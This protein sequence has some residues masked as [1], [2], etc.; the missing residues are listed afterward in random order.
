M[1]W[2][3]VLA[4]LPLNAQYSS[5]ELQAKRERLLQEIAGIQKELEQTRRSRKAGAEQVRTLQQ[6]IQAR[7]RLMQN[8]HADLQRIN[9]L[10]AQKQTS[11]NALQQ[12]LEDLKRSYARMVVY[13]YKNRS[14]KSWITFL[15]ASDDFNDALRR[16]RYVR[17]YNDYRRQ[18][19][20]LIATAQADLQR[21]I[22]QLN[23]R[24]QEQQRLLDQ[25]AEQR[26]LLLREKQ[27][28]DKLLQSLSRQEKELKKR[29]DQKQKEQ[30]KLKKQIA[31]RIRK[32]LSSDK[33]ADRS[34][35]GK[36]ERAA[37]L[38]PEAAALSKSFAANQGK[39]PWPVERGTITERFGTHAHEVFGNLKIKNNGI[40]IQTTKG[41]A[42]RAIFKGT[43]I[44]ILSNPAY[45]KAV[46]IRHGEYF[47][48]YSNLASVSVS[49]NE[50]VSTKQKI[51]QAYTDPATGL[52]TVHLEIWK[53][54]AMLNPEQW[55]SR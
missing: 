2:L 34:S 35:A 21:Q 19:A 39:L 28:K 53:G 12:E 3:F 5:S 33:A 46:L 38:T 47:T 15:M 42:V 4:A 44:A 49:A 31:E 30:E 40:D 14:S 8:L 1:F 11:I 36:G 55:L 7:E 18:Q 13:A 37:P 26:R 29:L 27:E 45:Q 41:A 50:E 48:V 51:G 54:A 25:E 22:D 23:I 17:R 24:M 20:A 32:E 6:S 9:G 16:L 43:V 10:I 52:T